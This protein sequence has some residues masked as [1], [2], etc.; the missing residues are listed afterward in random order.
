MLS[1][2]D[3]R[4][5]ADVNG[6]PLLDTFTSEMDQFFSQERDTDILYYVPE[7]KQ[8]MLNV[9]RNHPP[10]RLDDWEPAFFDHNT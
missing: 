8:R 3:V 5:K 1:M 7:L 4:R 10:P 6:N 9:I 2:A